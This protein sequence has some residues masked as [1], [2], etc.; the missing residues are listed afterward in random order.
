M[1]HSF[2]QKN[3]LIIPLANFIRFNKKIA[4]ERLANLHGQFFDELLDSE[5]RLEEHEEFCEKLLKKMLFSQIVADFNLG[6]KGKQEFISEALSLLKLPCDKAEDFE[7]AWNSL[8]EFEIKSIDVFQALIKLAKQGKSIYL[9][10]RANE[11]HAQKILDLFKKYSYKESSLLENL[12]EPVGALPLAI[13]ETSQSPSIGNIYLCLSYF[14]HTL[15]EQPIGFL[16]KLFIPQSNSGLLTQLLAYLTTQN[17]TKEEIL[18]INPYENNNA[19]TKKLAL[20]IISKDNFYSELRN[21]A[22]EDLVSRLDPIPE[23][24]SSSEHISLSPIH[25]T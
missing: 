14:Y 16:T 2:Q 19:I 25:N 6:K 11:L 3:I 22:H 21:S 13:T 18:L 20:D 8:L 24:S 15:V 12:P 5:E 9:I 4:G 7:S 23:S 1:L 17:K 10:G